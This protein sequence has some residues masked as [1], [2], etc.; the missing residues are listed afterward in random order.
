MMIFYMDF[1]SSTHHKRLEK[2]QQNSIRF[3]FASCLYLTLI[4]PKKK[5]NKNKENE[6]KSVDI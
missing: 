3:Y 4:A 1:F 5:R 6:R 2:I